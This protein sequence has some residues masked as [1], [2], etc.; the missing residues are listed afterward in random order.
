MK[1]SNSIGKLNQSKKDSK[2][3]K[4]LLGYLFK[5]KLKFTF[6]LACIVT[7]ALTG[8]ASSL[9]LQV[10]IDD[11]ISP[12]LLEAVPNFSGLFRVILLMAGLYLIGVLA[13]LFYNRF[14]A[15]IS[16]QVLKEIRDEMFAH[17]Q[18]LSIKYFDTHTHGDLMSHYTNDTD[19][20]RQMLSQSIPQLISSSMT[21]TA[22]FCSMLTLSF[23][24]TAVVIVFLV[25]ALTIVKTIAGRSGKFFIAQQKSLGDV[26]G[27]IEE[28]IH[29]QKVVKVFC[30]EGKAKERFN[31]LNE[32]LCLNSTA[33]N[34]YVN[35]LMPIMNNLGYVLYV[36]IALFGG[37]LAISGVTNFSIV[38]SGVISLGMIASFLQLSRN[39]INPIA[40]ISQQINSIAMALAGAERIFDLLDEES[41]SDH[42]TVHLVNVTSDDGHSTESKDYTGHW[43][44]KR[45]H[46]MEKLSILS[47]KVILNLTMSILNM[48]QVSEFYMILTFTLNQVKK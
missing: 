7:S 39:F 31:V 18:T 24:L 33:A 41:E 9:F 35:I 12:L 40:Q 37:I 23:W 46:G 5:H 28:M 43:S 3:F 17:M 44:W 20:L 1:Q 26:N 11:Y 8:V 6:V 4:R 14:M 36:A 30:Y 48:N 38:G 27:Y 42:G 19:T 13:T 34:K 16:Q 22:V 15:I 32:Q 29:G 47:Y 2:T 45:D 25:I 10:L 21:V